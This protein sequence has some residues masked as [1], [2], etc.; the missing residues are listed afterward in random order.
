MLVWMIHHFYR[1]RSITLMLTFWVYVIAFAILKYLISGIPVWFIAH[2]CRFVFGVI[3][4]KLY[5]L[6][7][8][9]WPYHPIKNWCDT[10]KYILISC[11]NLVWLWNHYITLNLRITSFI[12]MVTQSRYC[13][14]IWTLNIYLLRIYMFI[15]YTFGFH[16]LVEIALTV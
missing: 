1:R 13:T 3:L 6:S 4:S 10:Q 5:G 8:I 9:G 2:L 11:N 15:Q 7:N 14:M 12:Y 16:W